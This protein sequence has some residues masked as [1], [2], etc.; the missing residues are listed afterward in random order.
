MS[1]KQ[2]P[3]LPG[4]VVFRQADDGHW[5][6]LGEVARRPGLNARAARSQAIVDA[7]QGRLQVGTAYAAVLRS[8]WRIALEWDAP[9]AN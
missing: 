8:E 7:C 1:S 5:Q 4:F 9:T 3:T 2:Q 6:C